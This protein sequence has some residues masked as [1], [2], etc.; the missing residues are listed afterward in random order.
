MGPETDLSEGHLGTR[1]TV[2]C[3]GMGQEFRALKCFDVRKAF[4]KLRL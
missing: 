3:G 2:G 1:R 4:S